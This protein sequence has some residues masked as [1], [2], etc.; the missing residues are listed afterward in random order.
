[1]GNSAGLF[2]RVTADAGQV[3]T[4]KDGH[5]MSYSNLQFYCN[6]NVATELLLKTKTKR[7]EQGAQGS[8]WRVTQKMSK[9]AAKIVIVVRSPV[10]VSIIC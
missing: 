1:M 4:H 5:K 3:L 10:G 2:C 8:E 9:R 7:L 6:C